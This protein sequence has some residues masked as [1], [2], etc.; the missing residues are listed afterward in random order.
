MFAA[1]VERKWYSL[2]DTY[3]CQPFFDKHAYP[4]VSLRCGLR[5]PGTTHAPPAPI[6]ASKLPSGA[7][8]RPCT[9]LAHLLYEGGW[10]AEGLHADHGSPHREITGAGQDARDWQLVTYADNLDMHETDEPAEGTSERRC[11][12]T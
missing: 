10:L 11:A 12:W 9:A 3:M 5:R 7:G 8:A 1:S 6:T 4:G 2:K